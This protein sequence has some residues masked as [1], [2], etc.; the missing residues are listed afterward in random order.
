[1]TCEQAATIDDAVRQKKEAESKKERKEATARLDAF[2]K[3]HVGHTLKL[4][5]ELEEPDPAPQR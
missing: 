4:T 2:H 1:M 5:Q 3:D